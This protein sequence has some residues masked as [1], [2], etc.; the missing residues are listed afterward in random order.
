MTHPGII[1]APKSE[2]EKNSTTTNT[3]RNMIQLA[4]SVPITYEF[5]FFGSS[6]DFWVILAVV[7]VDD[8]IPQRRDERIIEELD[9]TNFVSTYPR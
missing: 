2:A 3:R 9:Q 5:T 8:T 4:R 6:L 1:I 7:A